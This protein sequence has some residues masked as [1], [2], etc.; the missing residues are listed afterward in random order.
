[1]FLLQLLK[2]WNDAAKG[3]KSA[4]LPRGRYGSSRAKGTN[5]QQPSL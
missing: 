3:K 2:F 1:M 5:Y 4:E